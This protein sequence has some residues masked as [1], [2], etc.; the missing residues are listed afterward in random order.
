MCQELVTE[1]R[2]DWITHFSLTPF[3]PVL[4]QSGSDDR[5]VDSLVETC[6]VLTFYG[7]LETDDSGVIQQQNREVTQ[8]FRKRQTGTRVLG[9]MTLF[10]YG[11]RTHL[12]VAFHSCERCSTQCA[13][14]VLSVLML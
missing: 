6:A 5:R 1:F 10:H 14:C 9:S 11:Y 12:G 4:I 7:I 3:D 2:Q 13:E 8:M